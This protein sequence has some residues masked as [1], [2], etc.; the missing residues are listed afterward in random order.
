VKWA[1]FTMA[2][3]PEV[4]LRETIDGSGSDALQALLDRVASS[5]RDAPLAAIGHRIVHGG[6][7]YYTPQRITPG[8]LENLKRLEP[9]A[10]N[11]LPR[12]IALIETLQQTLPGIPHIACFD[13]AFHHDLPEVARRLPLPRAFDA[14]G[15]RRYGFHGL[16]YAYL[17][18]ELGRVAGADVAQGR[19]ILAHLGN[20]SSLAAVRGGHSIDTSMCFTPLGGVIMST[21]SGDLDP[22]L[23]TFLARTE[24]FSADQIEELL[25]HESGLL[26]ISKSTGDM[27]QLL[28]RERTDAACHLAVNMYTYQIRKWIGAFAAAL[29]GL[30]TLVFSGGI[31]EHA[32]AVRERICTGLDFLG[33]RLDPDRNANNAAVI[34]VSDAQLVVR[35]IATDEEVMIAKAAGEILD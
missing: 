31:G 24:G 13:T 34:S 3:R 22:G 32:P 12:S 16:S 14:K 9:F 4:L 20:G 7:D 19:V 26:A 10:P 35:V 5:A 6:P 11:H 21:R 29:G 30:D 18:Q 17:L 15:V 1:L 28:D 8:L 27:R 2:Q 25:S 23:V 33:I